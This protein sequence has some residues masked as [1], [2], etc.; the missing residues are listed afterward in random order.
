MEA[1]KISGG[2]AYCYHVVHWLDARGEPSE[3][4]IDAAQAEVIR[5]TFREYVAVTDH[6][7]RQFSRLDK[8]RDW[9][10]IELSEE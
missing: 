5:R 7:A 2:N 1:G 9:S 8:S 10:S 4:G 3:R 6:L